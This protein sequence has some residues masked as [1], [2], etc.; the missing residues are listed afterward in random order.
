MGS[1]LCFGLIAD[2][3]SYI[4]S[5]SVKDYEHFSRHSQDTKGLCP[6][7]DNTEQRHKD[8]VKKAETQALA[9]L[10]AEHPEVPEEDVKVHV[11]SG[12][13]NE[14]KKRAATTAARPHFPMEDVLRAEADFR[15][16][17]PQ[18]HNQADMPRPLAAAPV[19]AGAPYPPANPFLAYPFGMTRG[20]QTAQLAVGQD[21]NVPFAMPQYEPAAQPR[22]APPW[23]PQV[24]EAPPWPPQLR[25][26]QPGVAQPWAAQL[27]AAQPGFTQ[28]WAAQPQAAQ[29]GAAQ[30][31]YTAQPRAAR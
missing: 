5:K 8:D 13:K 15:R 16:V 14:D 21:A 6:L 30:P 19:Q 9:L 4:C 2:P 10:R 27:Q 26:A 11:S 28:L 1:G 7:F 3:R 22:V 25:A 17:L 20:Q 23:P 12:I 24:Q 18:V 31:P 29:P